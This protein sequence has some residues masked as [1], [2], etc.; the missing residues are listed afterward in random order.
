MNFIK[1]NVVSLLAIVA[2]VFVGFQIQSPE[3]N[4]D[5][6]EINIDNTQP[7]QS[8]GAIPGDTLDGN[9]FC[10]GGVCEYRYRKDFIIGT[11]TAC[12]IEAPS[13]GLGKVMKLDTFELNVRT[14]TGTAWSWRVGT[15]TTGTNAVTTFLAQKTIT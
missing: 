4:V 12:S 7:S 3:V 14:A 2:V 13:F 15:S 10:V 11:T 1:Q 8:I 9:R 6:P 5:L